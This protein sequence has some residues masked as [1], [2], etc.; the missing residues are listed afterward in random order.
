ME[1]D[2]R[3]KK[4]ANKKKDI[5]GNRS[6]LHDLNGQVLILRKN[7]KNRT[8]SSSVSVEASE[9]CSSSTKTLPTK[10]PKPQFKFTNCTAQKSATAGRGSS[11][12]LRSKEDDIRKKLISQKQRK[13]HSLLYR[14]NINKKSTLS[15]GPRNPVNTLKKGFEELGE[16]LKNLQE[17]GPGKA[18]C[19]SGLEFANLH[20]NKNIREDSASRTI[21]SN[22]STATK[23]PP[24]EASVSPEIQCG[25]HSNVLVSAAAVT[26]ICYGAGHLV[27]GVTDKRKCRSRG[28][29][30]VG[31]ENANLFEYGSN[32]GKVID[33]SQ[34]S[35]IPMPA[36]ASLLW[37]LPP[38]DEEYE[39]NDSDLEKKLERCRKIPGN[40]SVLLDL[41]S[42]PSTLSGN[43]SDF[44]SY[45]VSS[46]VGD[47]E[48]TGKTRIVWRSPRRVPEQQAFSG[49]SSRK[50][51]EFFLVDTSH[52]TPMDKT[53][54]S[55]EDKDYS[56]NQI[57][58]SAAVSVGSLS[59]GNVI[60]TPDSNSSSERHFDDYEHQRI[61]FKSEFELVTDILHGASLS[62]RS[63]MSICDASG[64]DMHFTDL[65]S[66]S[67][68][69][70]LNQLP[71]KSLGKTSSVFD[72]MSE[73]LSVSQMRISWMDGLVSQTHE[74][75]RFDCCRCLSDEEVDA[76]GCSDKHQMAYPGIESGANKECDM[77]RNSGLK[78]PVLD[79]ES[80]F[81]RIEKPL[82]PHRRNSCAESISTNGGGL[83]ASGDSD[84]TICCKD[85]FF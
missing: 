24:V 23:T 54:N 62:P 81:L 75:D 66:H 42:S 37:L 84:W 68:S 20:D 29:L 70:D 51:D 71:Q 67:D 33:E 19:G 38:C 27:S 69:I 3:K 31:G 85:H 61:H 12:V 39:G 11:M 76:E 57:G 47:T 72:S 6:P 5:S 78:S 83:V 18:V 73:N 56:Y 50:I 16:K 8:I 65:A 2:S 52:C 53:I 30:T 36:E 22:G 21:D 13:N 7:C 55:R 10:K 64:F 1:K 49:P 82:S 41:G 77:L 15:S 25:S 28:I 59:S 45:G 4:H 79:C 74:M 43:A 60:Q 17:S 46:N 9:G 35:L 58:D 34:A 40:D 80:T 48:S 63:K 26:P 14:R 44:D 32:E